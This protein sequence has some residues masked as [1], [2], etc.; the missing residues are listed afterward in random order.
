MHS[1]RISMVPFE[2]KYLNDYFSGFSAEIT[3]FQWPEPFETIEDARALLQSFL[4]EMA[5]GETLL[6]AILSGDGGFLGSV[7]VHGLTGDCPELGIWIIPQAQNRGYAYEALNAVLDHV[8]SVWHKDQF[9]YEADVRNA[10]SIRLL[11]KFAEKYEIVGQGLE[12]LTTDSGKA[13]EL[14]GY[15]LKAR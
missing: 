8:R 15:V 5:Q 10:A 2:M 9:Y 11:H 3:R 12:R 7:E 1:D 14:Q 4:D 13:L 6:Y